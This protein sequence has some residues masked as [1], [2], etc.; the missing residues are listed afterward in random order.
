MR[1]RLRP[2]AAI[3][4]A[5]ALTL[6]CAVTASAQSITPTQRGE[7]ETIIREYLLSHP[8][9]L[10]DVMA[11]LEKRQTAAEASMR[12]YQDRTL[13]TDQKRDALQALASQSRTQILA[14]LGPGAGPAYADSSRWLAS[15]TQ[16]RAFTVNPDG[17]VLTRSLPATRPALTTP[18]PR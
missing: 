17:N 13:G 14:T 3:L 15:L 18:A 5:G 2:F 6:P 9:L 8:E 16:G 7:I 1:L 11:E 12:I 4:I 10:Q